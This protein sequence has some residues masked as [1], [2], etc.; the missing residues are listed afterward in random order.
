MKNDIIIV[1]DSAAIGLLLTEFLKKLGYQNIKTTLNGK[2]GIDLFKEFVK[3]KKNPIVFL[4]YNLPDMNAKSIMTQ[5]LETKPNTKIIIETASSK[6]EENIKEVIRL[7]AYQYIPKPIRFEELKNIMTILEEEE[8]ILSESP[9]GKLDDTKEAYQ[10]IDLHFDTYKRATVVR[11][12]E[13]SQMKEENVLSYLKKLESDGK[14]MPLDEI[15]E[16][17]CSSCGSL[18]LAQV[19]HCP[20]C[21]S[22]KFKRG[23]LIEHFKCGNFSEESEY[24]ND[25]C[26]KCKKDIKALGVDYRTIKNRYICKSCGEFFEEVSSSFLCLKCNNKFKFDDVQWKESMEYQLTKR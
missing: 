5:L 19:F 9:S 24:V 8:A 12:A 13:K 16:I 10:K 6:E 4:D 2:S 17:S 11:L 25:K 7:G 15:R 3:S 23:K 14:I 1:E 20:S 22:S 18:M 21:N 26:P